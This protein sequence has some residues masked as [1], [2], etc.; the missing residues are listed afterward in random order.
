MYSD[1]SSRIIASSVSNINSLSALQS[2]VFPTPVGPRKMSDAIGFDGSFNPARD[3]WIASVTTLTA[4]SCPINLS[5]SLS[6][7]DKIRALSLSSIF[8]AGMP[9]QMETTLAISSATTSSRS[10]RSPRTSVPSLASASD[11]RLSNSFNNCGKVEYFSSAALSR[12]CSRSHLTIS[13]FISAIFSCNSETRSTPPRSA[14]HFAVKSSCFTFRLESSSS[15]LRS[16]SEA[17]PTFLSLLL[18][19]S[20]FKESRSISSWITRRSISSSTSGFEV[21]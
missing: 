18:S 3:L 19:K 16:R 17:I 20:D 7:I 21:N 14:I 11:S 1:I 13:C 2:S 9:V 12:L 8:C 10:M 15:I 4:S 5:L 6:P